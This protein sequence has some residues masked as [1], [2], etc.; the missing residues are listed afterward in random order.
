MD[1]LPGT[2]HGN[3][4]LERV[5]V[6]VQALTDNAKPH[7]RPEVPLQLITPERSPLNARGEQYPNAGLNA[8]LDNRL[9]IWYNDYVVD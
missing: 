9:T 1:L 4:H 7:P 5:R 2:R 8:M 6:H 3:A